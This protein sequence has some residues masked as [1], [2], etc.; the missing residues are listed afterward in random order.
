MKLIDQKWFQIAIF[1]EVNL[2]SG[3]MGG[4]NYI[5]TPLSQCPC[6]AFFNSRI[7][8]KSQWGYK[9]YCFQLKIPDC[10]F[11][12]SIS[13]GDKIT[14]QFPSEVEILENSFHRDGFYGQFFQ[15]AG[16]LTGK[17]R[18][19]SFPH[20]S[21]PGVSFNTYT[22]R[23]RSCGLTIN[24]RPTHGVLDGVVVLDFDWGE[25]P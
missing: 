1:N 17:W 4:L 3:I 9:I 8:S 11:L 15:W 25:P 2:R 10:N 23:A 19:K 20:P 24:E 22:V 18:Q 21:E 14:V 13:N 12:H 16:A 7:L 5:F 6:G